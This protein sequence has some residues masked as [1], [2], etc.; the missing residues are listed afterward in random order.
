MSKTTRYSFL[1]LLATILILTPLASANHLGEDLIQNS[2]F[3]D[4]NVG[5]PLYWT[6]PNADWNVVQVRGEEGNYA[7]MLETSKYASTAK[8]VMESESFDAEEG[9]MFL[10]TARVKSTNAV[11]TKAVIRGY[12]SERKSWVTLK[13]FNPS[14]DKQHAFITVPENINALRVRLE[15]GYVSDKDKGAARS[16]FDEMR[17]IDPAV[18]NAEFY[19]SKGT[20]NK[21]GPLTI[22]PYELSLEEAKGSKALIKVSS[23]GKT[24]NS[25]V[26]APNEPVEF[27]SEGDK[28]LVFQVDDVFITSEHPE[29]RLSELLAGR[30]ISEAPAIKPV[31]EENLILYL[32]LDENADLAAYD[33]SG[34]NNHATIYGAEWIKGMENYALRLDG[35][36]DYI[37]VPNTKDKFEEGDHTFSLWVKST[38][39]RD[40]TKYVLCHYNWRIIWQSDTK[41]G[42]S[43]GRMNNK[44]G[45]TYTV[46]ADVAEIKDEWI[47]VA[48]VYKPSENRILL[49]IN[50][51]LAGEEK[52]GEDSIWKDY[53]SHNLLIGTSKHGSAT[54]FE[55]TVD[56]VRIYD[57]ALTQQEIRGLMSKPL[58]LSGI[59]S[60]QSSMSLERGMT[61]PTGNGFRIQYSDTPSPNL[62]LVDGEQ[63]YRYALANVSAGQIIFLKNASGVPAVRLT[64]DKITDK[65]LSLSDIWVADEKANVPVL[66]VKS[67]DLPKIRAYEPAVV[68]VTIFND[69]QKPYPGDGSGSIDLYLG[70]DEVGSISIFGSLAPGETLVHSFEL[71]SKEAGD[72][73]LRAVVST[74]YGTESLSNAIRIQAPINPPVSGIPLYVEETESGIKLGLILKGP[75]INGESWKDD[76][77]VSIRLLSPL[78]SRTFLDRSYPI[79]GTENSIE[80]PYED[81]YQGDGQYLITVKFREGENIV[82][83]KV[84]GEDGIYNPPDNYYLLLLLPVPV[85]VYIARRKLFTRTEK[86]NQVSGEGTERLQL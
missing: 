74:K 13:T 31:K 70:E 61:L 57:R 65:M 1:I 22:G 6:T 11:E 59:S 24:I 69:G 29:I 37:E 40:S 85:V 56:E 72:N 28:Y 55:G 50:G 46:T 62:A 43:T 84:S 2:G 54:F 73:E 78:G 77:Q 76:A 34:G 68:K 42:F 71:N 49:Y 7:L 4:W 17:I 53:G 10:V 81:F 26:L 18:E 38:G 21:G 58:G 35:L 64:V 16:S 82:V 5:K 36:T 27:R 63:T 9:D 83:T 39:I 48:G 47:H 12:N 51:E 20:V 25:A 33:Y 66:K 67:I 19:V 23:S 44:D 14:S 15:A 79:S 32:P 75:G 80:I 30:I 41:I 60:Y 8:G 52:I 45:P 86:R 3:E